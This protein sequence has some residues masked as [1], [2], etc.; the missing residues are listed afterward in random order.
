MNAYSVCLL[1]SLYFVG[2]QQTRRKYSCVLAQVVKIQSELMLCGS[3]PYQGVFFST[4]SQC[5]RRGSLLAYPS[6]YGYIMPAVFL[7]DVEQDPLLIT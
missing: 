5:D 3:N 7:L 2:N 1:L 4:P 6:S